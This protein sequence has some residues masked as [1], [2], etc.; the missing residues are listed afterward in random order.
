QVDVM[1]S[2]H[3][4]SPAA[5]PRALNDWASPRYVIVSARDAN[6]ADEL[7]RAYPAAREVIFTHDSGAVSAQITATGQVVTRKHRQF[8]DGERATTAMAS[9]TESMK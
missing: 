8:E 1:L 7:H 4:G 9:W 3:H 6:A 5:N 2:P